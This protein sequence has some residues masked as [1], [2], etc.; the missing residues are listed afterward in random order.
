MP[1]M[2]DLAGAPRPSPRPRHRGARLAALL[3]PLGLL[4]LG[5][6]AAADTLAVGPGQPFARPEDA[7]ARARPGDVIEVHPLPGGA[8][9]AKTALLV[10]TARLAIR[11]VRGAG[12]ARVHLDG[13]GFAY[14]GAGKVPRAIVQFDPAA[15]GCVLEGFDLIGA[16]N[17]SH[18]G[19]GVRINQASD[20]TVRDCEIHGND[21]G[22]MSNGEFAKGTASAQRIEGCLIHDNGDPTQP[23]LN[24][25]LYLGG[26]SALV[27]GCDIHSAT[28]GHNLKSRAHLTWVEYCWIH[29][30]KNREV[31][32]VD[33]AGNT[34]VPGSDAVLLGD[35]IAKGAAGAVENKEV[36][37]FGQDGGKG[38]TGTLYVVQDTILTPYAAAVV[39]LSAPGA[40]VALRNDI[41]CDAGPGAGPH[42]LV[43]ARGGAAA[44]A[45]SGAGNWLGAGFAPPAGGAFAPAENVLAGA[46]ERPPFR[47]PASDWHLLAT[48]ASA[49]S[50]VFGA[51]VPLAAIH[52]P[53]RP[54]APRPA[55]L[56]AL[57]QYEAPGAVRPRAEGARP[58]P[59]AL[60]R[61]KR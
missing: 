24:H 14:S 3:A 38:H 5:A 1:G 23:G 32:L 59:G 36:I 30:S 19:A 53:A 57:E 50:R 48:G 17:D 28:T 45:A 7:L 22:I 9:Y 2:R 33:E 10:R 27:R 31:E 54:G 20:V 16:H 35:V 41:V 42:A 18:N 6:R 58:D 56:A 21:M 46:G 12:G 8:G 44:S 25:N 49:A 37:H 43:E 51:G 13:T 61:V 11:A 52:L 60:G 34:D 4:A 29:D 40:A 26:T 55:P 15:S 39:T 47:D